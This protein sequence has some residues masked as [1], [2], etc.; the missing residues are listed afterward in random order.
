MSFVLLIFHLQDIFKL[1]SCCFYENKDPSLFLCV[2]E[3][4]YHKIEITP[5]NTPRIDKNCSWKP[6]ELTERYN[7]KRDDTSI[8]KEFSNHIKIMLKN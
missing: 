7:N 5:A 3:E 6:I 1:F 4:Q 2:E 8:Q